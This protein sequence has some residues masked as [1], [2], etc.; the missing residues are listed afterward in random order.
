MQA[1]LYIREKQK[2]RLKK[3]RRGRFDLP[4]HVATKEIAPFPTYPPQTWVSKPF[5]TIL[6]VTLIVCL[7][8]CFKH[9]CVI[10]YVRLFVNI[11]LLPNN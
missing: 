4:S 1:A 2:Q 8:L 6:H 10:R 7:F 3:F 11:S 9:C 5:D